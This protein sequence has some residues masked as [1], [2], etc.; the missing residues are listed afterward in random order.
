MTTLLAWAGSW[1]EC[2]DEFLLTSRW[3]VLSTVLVG[4]EGILFAE[5]KGSKRQLLSYEML[6]LSIGISVN[7]KI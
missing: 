7:T 5:T 6:L 1:L 4:K 2:F 3:I